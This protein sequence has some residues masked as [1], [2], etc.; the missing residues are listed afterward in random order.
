MSQKQPETGARSLRYTLF[1]PIMIAVMI[2]CIV[3]GYVIGQ[4]W[5]ERAM[6]R[7]LN[8][9]L[10][11]CIAA[12]IT[13]VL[14]LAIRRQFQR[15]AVIQHTVDALAQGQEVARTHMRPVDEI[16]QLGH[17]VDQYAVQVKRQ[18]D[19]LQ[20]SL[21][22]QRREYTFIASILDTLNEGVIV[23][24]IG[25]IPMFVNE[26]AKTILQ[27]ENP[28]EAVAQF[29]LR[30]LKQ[31]TS[32]YP[33]EDHRTQVAAG[34]YTLGTPIIVQFNNRLV[35]VQ[36]GEMTKFNGALA[37][38]VLLLRDV[39][40]NT[41]KER[42]QHI[43]IERI[44]EDVQKPLEQ[45][46]ESVR[47][48]PAN[49]SGLDIFSKQIEKH[50]IALQKLVVELR[51][52]AGAT[53]DR[54]TAADIKPL[55]AKEF[56]RALFNEW[57]PVTQVNQLQLQVQIDVENAWL[58]VDERRLRWAFGNIIDNA[59]KY[60]L[61]GGIVSLEI[62]TFVKGMLV[63]RVRDNGVGITP[64]EL[65]HVFTRF[66]RGTPRNAQGEEIL[67]AGVGQGLTTA[68]QIIEAHRGKVHV[69]S[70]VGAGTTVYIALPSMLAPEPQ[71]MLNEG[72]N[73][74]PE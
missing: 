56:I 48:Q 5:G 32:L 70:T 10:F 64:E 47:Q 12:T 26:Q 9:V 4:T 19:A 28:A 60:T 7:Q 59:N 2:L 34:L 16:G 49:T 45:A 29:S 54:V 23:L 69:K 68:R 46:L 55:A 3:V 22:R 62:K 51:D 66:F 74:L 33:T 39:T 43:W 40:E 67:I 71:E 57:R 72:A 53:N 15:V 25:G 63:L 58:Q 24:D 11:A 38:A 13:I 30:A 1:Y 8:G 36:A 21:R 65:P 44:A 6:T 50:S 42:A 35:R 14:F 52:L 73:Y 27:A 18:S 17:S 20:T 41:W 61:P 37:G 31:I